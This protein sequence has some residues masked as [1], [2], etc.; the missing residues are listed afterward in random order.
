M[1]TEHKRRKG[2]HHERAKRLAE[3]QQKE[4]KRARRAFSAHKIEYFSEDR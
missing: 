4:Q 2:A 3:I 1:R